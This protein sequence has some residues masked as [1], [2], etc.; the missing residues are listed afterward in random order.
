[1]RRF[2]GYWLRQLLLGGLLL[3]LLGVTGEAWAQNCDVNPNAA[4]TPTSDRN[5]NK[6]AR[7]DERCC[8]R[9]NPNYPGADKCS[10]PNDTKTIPCDEYAAP[11]RYVAAVCR[12]Q[13]AGD[14]DN[15]CTGDACDNCPDVS[16]P[17]QL[18][19]DKDGVGDACDNCKAV[20]N[21][22]QRDSDGDGVG[23]ACDTCPYKANPPP[24]PGQ[25]Q[26]DSDGDMVGDA[27]DNCPGVVNSDQKDSDGDSR[28]DAC[29]K[30]KFVASMSDVDTDGDGVGDACDNCP[31]LSNADQKDTDLDRVGDACDNCVTVFNPDQKPSTR[32]KDASGKFI[33]VACEPGAQGGAGCSYGGAGPAPASSVPGAA[34][35]LLLALGL[36]CLRPRRDSGSEGR[37]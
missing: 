34:A 4:C 27:C 17:D 18:D 16:N 26:P 7:L 15:D 35:L 31:M 2:R 13:Q 19:T 11:G 28:G 29:D 8:R 21:K 25:P 36:G 22:N 9:Y 14:V 10:D 3:G 6:I 1:M 24:M 23:D 5:C 33:G 37:L 32:F 30:C 12:P 20:P